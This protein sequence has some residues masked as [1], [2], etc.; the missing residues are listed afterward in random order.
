M[1]DTEDV[2]AWASRVAPRLRWWREVLVVGAVYLGYELAR[3]LVPQDVSLALSHGR[4][5]LDIEQTLHLDP[6]RWLN[7]ALAGS[8]VLS[9]VAAYYYAALHYLIT[10]VVLVW[11]YRTQAAQYRFART[12]IVAS[13]ALGMVGYALLPTA[14]PRL[15]GGGT[16]DGGFVDVLASVHRYGWWGGEASVPRGLGGLADQFAAMPSL[17]VGWAL[18]C[19]VLVARFARHR[20][21]RLLGVAYPVGTSLVVMATGNHYLLDVIG[22]AAVM[23][24]GA[25][26][27]Q[28]LARRGPRRPSPVSVPVE[29]TAAVTAP[30]SERE[31]AL[32]AA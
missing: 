9:V 32:T 30:V 25:L 23:G 4:T 11:I 6:E 15:L 24:L 7:S 10:P 29:A 5:L 3:G 22:G 31:S 21:V 26:V 2:S 14:P 20:V 12:W 17:H 18:W 8:T 16:G 1:V 27:A 28:A 19:G 13:T